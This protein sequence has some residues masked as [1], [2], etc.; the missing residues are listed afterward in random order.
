[1]PDVLT[2]EQRRFCMSRI[3]GR[4]TKPE[5]IVRRMLHALGYRY[6]LHVRA[7]P[8]T[9]D[10]VFPSRGKIIFVHGCFWHRHNCRYGRVRPATRR[11]FWRRKLEGNQ[12]RDRQTRR[13]LRR[14]GWDVLTVWE[15]QTRAPDVLLGRLVRYLGAQTPAST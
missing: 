8:G 3:Q 12:Q 15:C 7:L 14:M 9:P 4:D 2:P 13:K 5:M 1:M 10:L 11:E 6:R